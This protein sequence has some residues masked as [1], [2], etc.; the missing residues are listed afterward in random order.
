MR[1]S[2]WIPKVTNTY[3]DYVL[4]IAFPLQYDY[5]NVPQYCVINTLP[6]LHKMTSFGILWSEERVVI[7]MIRSGTWVP[8]GQEIFLFSK[9][10][11]VAVVTTQPS[12]D[13]VMD[14]F[15]PRAKRPGA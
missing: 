8:A 11:G 2:C 14:S 1:I 3:S 9:T 13:V 6:V 5:T 4:L 15:S 7:T 12:I 10:S